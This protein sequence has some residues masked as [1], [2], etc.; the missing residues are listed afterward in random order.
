MPKHLAGFGDGKGNVP[1]LIFLQE[2]GQEFQKSALL[3]TYRGVVFLHKLL[4]AS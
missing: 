1:I 2:H 3:R 4:D